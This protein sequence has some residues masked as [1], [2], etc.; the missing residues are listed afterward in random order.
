MVPLDKQEARILGRQRRN[1]LKDRE[2]RNQRIFSFL[3]PY[4]EQAQTIGIYVSIQEEV[5]TLEAIHW[6]FA[7]GKTVCVPKIKGSTLEMVA[8]S[9]VEALKPASFG[10]LEPDEGHVI[11][12]SKIDCMVI[13]MIAYDTKMHR[14]GYG[15]GYYDS[16]LKDAKKKVGLAYACQE[17]DIINVDPW[18]ID[19]DCI[20]T[21]M[22]VRVLE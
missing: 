11:A 6:C 20:I 10:L 17:V 3:L 16:V 22:G 8:I 1:A 14:L 5:D 7:H 13:P 18:D 21:E 2:E 4:L 19:M 15:K 9:S 12:V